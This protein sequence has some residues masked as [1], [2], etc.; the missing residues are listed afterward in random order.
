MAAIRY[1]DAVE[2]IADDEAETIDG[3]IKAAK[4]ISATTYKDEGHAIRSV[5]AKSHALLDGELTVLGGLPAELAQGLFATA[6]TYKVALRLST[7]PGDMLPDSVSTPRGLALKVFDV[8]GDQLS[9]ATGD[10]TQDFLMVDAPAFLA[11]EPK[12]FLG[13]L[14][15]LV[16]STDKVEWL[17]V[18]FS[19][20]LRGVEGTI[21]AVG[22]KSGK[23]IALGGHRASNPLGETYFT[24]VPIR[25][26]DYI[27]KV[28][29][30]PVGAL[31]ALKD[32]PVDVGERDD[33]LRAAVG[34]HFK[35]TGGEWEVQ[36]QLCRDLDK[37]PVEDAAVEWPEDA[38][39][40]VTVA[41]LTVAAQPSW[42]LDNVAAID[43]GLA[44]SPWH[45]L[46]AHRPLGGIM[47]A[48]KPV[49]TALQSERSERSGCPFH[50][51]ARRAAG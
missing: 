49:Y 8:P 28:R 1:T 44:F 9:G 31:A 37:M 41:R 10:A 48:R 13:S 14:K 39:P 24:Q 35:D 26:G 17:K 30:T 11:P 5:H 6:A 23:L 12:A 42:S 32:A 40:F 3:L 4:A 19:T 20:V 29:A 7:S 22:G 16:A 51:G 46:V 34:E 47:R 45:G 38:S 21:E 43:T 15:P 33:A 2:E 18:A 25:Y 27:A 36:V 50:E